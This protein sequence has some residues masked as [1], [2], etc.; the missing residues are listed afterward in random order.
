ML[1]LALGA[2][3]TASPCRAATNSAWSDPSSSAANWSNTAVHLFIS[4][5]SNPA[6]HSQIM[7][8]RGENGGDY[9]GIRFWKS[10][11]DTNTT[12][13]P[14]ANFPYTLSVP[15][16]TRDAFCSSHVGLGS[17]RQLILGGT[18]KGDFEVGISSSLIFNPATVQWDSLNSGQ[19]ANPRWYPGSVELGDGRVV[20]ASGSRYFHT[21]M[22]G[23]SQ[24]ASQAT[25]PTDRTLRRHKA[26]IAGGFDAAIAVPAAGLWPEA[27]E[28]RATA[29]SEQFGPLFFGGFHGGTG[30]DRYLNGIWNLYRD[31]DNP[32]G[33]DYTYSWVQRGPASGQFVPTARMEAAMGVFSGSGGN[34]DVVVMGGRTDAAVTGE[35]RCMMKSP[36]SG[37]LEWRE[38]GSLPE[39]RYGSATAFDLASGT[40]YVYGGASAVG[41]LPANNA[42]WK[43]VYAPGLTP[44]I[45][46]STLTGGNLAT[47]GPACRRG[48]AMVMDKNP[49]PY[50]ASGN[51]ARRAIVFGGVSSAASGSIGTYSDTVWVLWFKSTGPEWQAVVPAG[52]TSTGG[53]ERMGYSWNDQTQRLYVYG[54]ERTATVSGATVTTLLADTYFIGLRNLYL[55]TPPEARWTRMQDLA[56]TT[57]GAAALFVPNVYYSA[58]TEIFNQTGNSGSGS[59][60]GLG[61]LFS[62]WFPFMFTI[63]AAIA[64][65]SSTRV[66]YAGPDYQTR[67]L[68]PNATPSTAWSTTA[69]TSEAKGGSAVMYRLGKI[70]KCGSRDT[71]NGY[72]YANENAPDPL[73]SSETIDL[74]ATSPAWTPSGNLASGRVNFNLV[75]LPTGDVMALGGV[76]KF[77]NFGNT[78]PVYRPEVWSEA[79]DAWSSGAGGADHI[80]DSPLIRGYHSTCILLPDARLLAASGNPNLPAGHTNDLNTVN[81]LTPPYL[82]DGNGNLAARPVIQSCETVRDY[83]SLLHVQTDI[84]VDA[85]VL[86]R[87]GS[88]THGFNPEQRYVPLAEPTT[89]QGFRI[90]LDRDSLPPGDYYVFALKGQVPSIARW[91]RIGIGVPPQ[92]IVDLSGD[93]PLPSNFSVRWTSPHED[94][95]DISSGP[96]AEYELRVRKGTP[97]DTTHLELTTRLSAPAPGAAGVEQYFVMGSP[98]PVDGDRFFFRIRSRDANGLWSP[99][100]PSVGLTAYE[101]ADCEGTLAGGGGGGG[102]GYR[103]QR[104]YSAHTSAA[105]PYN[106]GNT[107]LDGVPDDQTI[108]DDLVLAAPP[109]RVNGQ[110][111]LNLSQSGLRHTKVTALRLVVVD[112]S[113]EQPVVPMRNQIM[114]GERVRASALTVH[115]EDGTKDELDVTRS[116]TGNAGDFLEVHLGTGGAASG[117]PLILRGSGLYDL[118]GADSS[119]VLVQVPDPLSQWRTIARRGLRRESAETAVESPGGGTIGLRLLTASTIDFVGHIDGAAPAQSVTR[120]L[121][122]AVLNSEEG[123]FTGRLDSLATDLTGGTSLSAFFDVAEPISGMHRSWVFELEASRSGTGVGSTSASR[124]GQVTASQTI[125]FGIGQN[126]PNPFSGRTSMRMG[127][128]NAAVVRVEIFDLSG[129]RV[130]TLAAKRFEPGYHILDWDGRLASGQH[131]NPGV[132]L[133]RMRMGTQ[134]STRRLTLLP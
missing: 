4:P 83:G 133:Y 68:D 69:L 103:S 114:T 61:N 47:V 109:A 74:N 60:A 3:A 14:V 131:A 11:S 91:V 97:I 62:E 122:S 99:W 39:P 44:W 18:A 57:T 5:S 59:W 92:K 88:V 102:G 45:T 117:T 23:G 54:G 43:G 49:Q 20:V 71:G 106:A 42:I 80:A 115:H 78:N 84:A 107:M 98:H 75:L 19:M 70:L 66:F 95:N 27:A 22:L 8:L 13:F 119:G 76:G 100:S 67:W 41:A 32:L 112:H 105:Q 72:D 26:T 1:L 40:V 86:L 33:T 113:S 38:L 16:P 104:A 17:G 132:Y 77:G 81:I 6:Y 73:A 21:V 118:R 125:V 65:Q 31:N 94:W 130:R 37:L 9:G 89:G 120:L 29:F 127:V 64:K 2:L 116:F 126:Q 53:R 58:Q 124:S 129:R 56:N 52:G 79:T 111:R 36:S 34:D 128:P 110:Y 25:A 93:C 28:G 85:V 7:W 108:V 63:P 87:P 134:L 15:A 30:T 90:P 46:W 12:T 96:T 50:D 35:I 82:W 55:T 48:L 10:T 24:A 51:T 101:E 123:P 121:P